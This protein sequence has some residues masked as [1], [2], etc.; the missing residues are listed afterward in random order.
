MKFLLKQLETH[1]AT[2]MRLWSAVPSFC[3]VEATIGYNN[4]GTFTGS[5]G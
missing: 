1:I 5:G 2:Q 4:D 3:K